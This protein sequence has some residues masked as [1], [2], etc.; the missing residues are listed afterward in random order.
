M[1][2]VWVLRRAGGRPKLFQVQAVVIACMIA[3][4]GELNQPAEG[5]PPR[6]LLGYPWV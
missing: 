5:K 3:A 2:Q 6:L 1:G 4:T